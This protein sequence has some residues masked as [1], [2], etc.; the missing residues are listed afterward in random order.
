MNVRNLRSQGPQKLLKED[1]EQKKKKRK[2]K[3]G[4]GRDNINH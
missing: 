1:G 2:K 3:K 4:E